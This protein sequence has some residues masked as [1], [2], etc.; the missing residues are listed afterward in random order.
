MYTTNE[1]YTNSDPWYRVKIGKWYLFQDDDLNDNFN[2]LIKMD[3][4][5]MPV[6]EVTSGR[7]SNPWEATTSTLKVDQQK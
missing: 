5:C 6:Y 3:E 2:V 7:S 4:T 1:E